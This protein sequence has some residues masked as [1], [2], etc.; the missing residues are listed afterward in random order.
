MCF[1]TGQNHGM[2]LSVSGTWN[3]RS[4][5]WEMKKTDSVRAEYGAWK[6][7]TLDFFYLDARE[8]K[9]RKLV[10]SIYYCPVLLFNF[11]NRNPERCFIYTVTQAYI[12]HNT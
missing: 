11:D 12:K 3:S 8:K 2:H 4:S 5:A 9:N 1:H 7:I 10:P 6:N